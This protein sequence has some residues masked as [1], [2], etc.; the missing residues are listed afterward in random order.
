MNGGYIM[1]DCMGI[2]LTNAEPQSISGIW[3]KAV[4]AME[5]DKPIIAHNCEYGTGVKVSPVTCFGWYINDDEIVIVGATLH[6]HIKD[7]DTATVLDVTS[8]S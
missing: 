4:E 5:A 7:D 2:D 8:N 6:I 3:N 1:V